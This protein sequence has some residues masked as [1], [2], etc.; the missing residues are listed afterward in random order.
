MPCLSRSHEP[1]VTVQLPPVLLLGTELTLSFAL[2][3]LIVVHADHPRFVH[4]LQ[5]VLKVGDG[6]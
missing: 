1:R 3:Y 2:T 4:T 6:I 5:Q